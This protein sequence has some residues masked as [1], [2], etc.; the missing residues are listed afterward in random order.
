MQN[1]I[2]ALTHNNISSKWNNY[3]NYNYKKIGYKLKDGSRVYNNE[4]GEYIYN[5]HNKDMSF[6]D[7][8]NCLGISRQAAH[9]SY[10]K[11]LKSINTIPRQQNISVDILIKS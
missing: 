6:R 7:I 4:H 8:G 2:A 1:N 10:H 5:L 9:Q 11:Y 3:Y